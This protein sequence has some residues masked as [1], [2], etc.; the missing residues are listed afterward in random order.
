MEFESEAVELILHEAEGYPYFLQEW[1]KHVWDAA[2]RS[3][4]TARDVRSASATALAALDEGFFMVRFDRL[5]RTE[6]RYLR[7]MAEL[8]RGPHRSGEIAGALGR[9]VTSTA[10]VRSKLI[11]KGMV[12]SPAHGDTGF[13]VPRFDGFMRRIMPDDR[14][15]T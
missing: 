11:S 9:T 4:I 5:T 10:P 1:G 3:P 7:A 8:G 2:E 14:W 6:R 13:T 12:W 15:R